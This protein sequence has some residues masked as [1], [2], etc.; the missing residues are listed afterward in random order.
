M[1]KGMGYVPNAQARI[2]K[3]APGMTLGVLVYDFEDPFFGA[4]IGALQAQA[5]ESGYSLVLGGFHRRQVAQ[6]D[7]EPLLKHQIDGLVIVGSG[8]LGDWTDA[9]GRR[10]IPMVRIGTGPL[11]PGVAEIGVDEEAGMRLAAEHLAGLGHRRIGYVGG[12]AAYQPQRYLAFCQALADLGQSLEDPVYADADGY[13]SEAG[14]GAVRARLEGGGKLPGAVVAASDLV[15]LGVLRALNEAGY[16]VPAD[17]SVVGFD[18]LPFA[19]MASPPLTTVRQPFDDLA[20]EAVALL[21]GARRP[22]V[23]LLL[24]PHLVIRASCAAARQDPAR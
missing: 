5:G 7:L 17:I 1:A 12:A 8:P 23:P 24:Q 6:R 19:A 15:A 22:D 10:A 11:T 16:R 14:Y 2:L 13:V 18:D 20:G 9:F 4:V 3:G 21:S